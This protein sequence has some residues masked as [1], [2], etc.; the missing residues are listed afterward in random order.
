MSKSRAQRPA[1]LSSAAVKYDPLHL[2]AEHTYIRRLGADNW[3]EHVQRLLSQSQ[4]VMNSSISH[5]KMILRGLFD[6]VPI[7]AQTSANQDG[8]AITSLTPTY[9]CLQCPTVLTDEDHL[10]H[11]NKKSHRFCESRNGP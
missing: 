6:A 9:M 4:E 1:L 10:K 11:G 8:R 7:V 3:E 2:V 5:Y